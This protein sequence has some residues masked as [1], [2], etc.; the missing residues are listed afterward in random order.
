MFRHR[1]ATIVLV[2]CFCVGSSASRSSADDF[3]AIYNSDTLTDAQP[4]PAQQAAATMR[5]PDG[6]SVDVFAS[7]PDVQNP[8]AVAWDVRGRMWVAE[9][10]TYAE[11]QQR[12]DL[13]LRDRVVVLHDT[14]H[15]GRADSRKV[16]TDNVQMLTSVEV[17]LGGV[18]LM[19]PP[20]LLFIPDADGDDVADGPAQVM[21]DGFTV[22]QDNYHNF[23]NGLRWGP[24]GWLYG[25]CGHSCP[26]RI[27]VPGSDDAARIPIDGG[28]WR[29]HP[30]RKV[31]EVLCHGTVNPWGHDWDENG[32]LFFINTVIGHLWHLMPGAHF[33]ESFGESMN[34]AVYERLDMIA[35]HYHF[36]TKSN[37][38]ESR[39]GKANDFG[40][41]HAHIGMMIYQGDAWPDTYRG[42]LFTL[43]M[44]GYRA[45]VERLQR[46]GAGYVAKHDPDFLIAEDPFFR[47][48][49]IT[50]GPDA[51][52]YVIDW[53]DTGECHESTGVHRTSGRIY[54]IS[55]GEDSS[56]ETIAKPSCMS[57][58]GELVG[59]WKDYQAGKTTP[60]SLR[61]LLTSS[62]EHLRVWA[63]RLLTDAWPLDTVVGPLASAVYP[64]DDLTLRELVR[65][66]RED[67]SGLVLLTLASTL[68]RLAPEYRIALASPLVE[69]AE[70]ANDRDLPS[71][72][73][74]GLI[75]AGESNPLALAKLATRCQ[76]PST[77][78][79]IARFV[80]SHS[81]DSPDALNYLL[82]SEISHSEP[83]QREV[84]QGLKQAV[85]GWTS[86]TKP[87]AWDAFSEVA[88]RHSPDVVLE[89]STLFGDGRALDEIRKIVLDPSVELATRRTALQ[90]LINAKPDDLREI[91]EA[92]LDVRPLNATAISG[93]ATYDD[94]E[95]GKRVALKYRRFLGHDR[96]AVIEML[97][98]RPSFASALLESLGSDNSSIPASDLTPF[99]ARQII[100]YGDA[101]LTKRLSEVWGELRDSPADKRSL[102]LRLK[103]Q[104]SPEVLSTANLSAGRELFAKTCAQC[105]VLYGEGSK[106]GPDLTGAQRSSLEYLLENVVD[107]SAV[108]GKDYR[109]TSVLLNNGLVLNGL[110]ISQD[111]KTL[112][113]QTPT[114]Q[115]AISVADID[116]INQTSLSAM[117]A[118][119]L[120]TLDSQQQR[121]LIGYLMH[122]TQVAVPQK[123]A[124]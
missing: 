70:F 75:P 47:G 6:F 60:E 56:V 100:G 116:E 108:V 107:P 57:G 82:A 95:I 65:M 40:G 81:D 22:A 86:A 110:I 83:M 106:V 44:H 85:R 13:S 29:F 119:I 39:H 25:R 109:N 51:N 76:W 9:N 124:Q 18:W 11:R 117:P 88:Q 79:W 36:D 21:L 111:S 77:N 38:T 104:L 68:Q 89:L 24:D 27:G 8:I 4:I 37:W 41:G 103:E 123:P 43:N 32:E 45:N 26:G 97:V 28:I 118:G 74:F 20:Q 49:E 93:L 114:E 112:V 94:A 87:A 50:V 58:S 115:K 7:E 96:P 33:K 63:I 99:H 2:H 84:L 91:C 102:I 46:Q 54:K 14:D 120:E 72:V 48:V 42:K 35:D 19:C 16:F 92:V 12:F 71:M 53:S 17:G 80:M 55:Y 10:Y 105:H 3:P 113:L 31:V 122:P 5:V 78:R 66:A 98:S 23:A 90:T 30:A 59:H 121:D 61:A 1:L 73:W 69:R 34:P 64:D 15:D 62:D 52:A 67:D 101:A